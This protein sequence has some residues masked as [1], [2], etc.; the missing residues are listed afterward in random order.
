MKH[1]VINRINKNPKCHNQPTKTKNNNHNGQTN[2]T[3]KQT[4]LEID[5]TQNKVLMKQ[6]TPNT[7]TLKN[8]E[9]KNP[10]TTTNENTKR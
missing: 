1:P 6:A 9:D 8:K 10:K 3:N 2:D 7:T 4:Q 5:T